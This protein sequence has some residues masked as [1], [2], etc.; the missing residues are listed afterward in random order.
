M[1]TALSVSSIGWSIYVMVRER[2]SATQSPI[3]FWVG[4]SYFGERERERERER[5]LAYISLQ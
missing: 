3:E 1:I 5:Y 2:R 4:A